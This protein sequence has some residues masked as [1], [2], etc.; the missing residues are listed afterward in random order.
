MHACCLNVEHHISDHVFQR[1]FK[2]NFNMLIFFF[3]FMFLISFLF[4]S[5]IFKGWQSGKKG[6]LPQLGYPLGSCSL[7]G[8]PKSEENIRAL[9]HSLSLSLS[10]SL[11]QCVSLPL[12]LSLSSSSLL[13]LGSLPP[14]RLLH[15]FSA[16]VRTQPSIGKLQ[17]SPPPPP[18]PPPP[19][20]PG[21]RH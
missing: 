16:G 6:S 5:L 2:S 17:P 7:S 18:P 10:L 11:S 20:K 21:Y 1:K 8:S 13:L 4:F 14:S 3:F 12:P 9:N 19:S 15:H